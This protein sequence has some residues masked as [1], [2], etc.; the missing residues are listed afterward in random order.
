MRKVLWLVVLAAVFA[1]CDDAPSEAPAEPISAD[2]P[3]ALDPTNTPDP[4]KPKEAPDGSIGSVEQVVGDT[5]LVRGD[6]PTELEA[7][8]WIMPGDQVKT[9]TDGKAA[10]QLGSGSLLRV[11]PDSQVE[12]TDFQR[13]QA[14]RS[15]TIKVLAGKFWMNVVKWVGEAEQSYIEVQTGNAVAG[16]RGTTLWG[17]T[18]RDVICSLEGDVEVR[19]TIGSNPPPKGKRKGKKK[20]AKRKRGKGKAAATA[21]GPMKL[22]AGQCASEMSKGRTTPLTPTAEQVQ[23]YLAEVMIADNDEG[24]E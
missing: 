15:G 18:A 7:G 21:G 17:D 8:N 14:K 9:G 16:I 3:D 1:G 13:S 2:S 20:P 4:S 22:I 11:G 24:G 23:E 19:S 12:I 10:V 6:T 5:K